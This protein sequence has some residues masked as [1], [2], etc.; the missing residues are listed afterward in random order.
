MKWNHALKLFSW[1]LPQIQTCNYARKK[2]LR[3][4]NRAATRA[5]PW[6]WVKPPFHKSMSHISIFHSVSSH[7]FARIYAD[8]KSGHTRGI[9]LT[10]S[11]RSCARNP[12]NVPNVDENVDHRP[13]TT[14]DRWMVGGKAAALEDGRTFR[15]TSSEGNKKIWDSTHRTA[16]G[17]N[18]PWVLKGSQDDITMIIIVMCLYVVINFHFLFS[19]AN[20]NHHR[21]QKI[22]KIALGDTKLPQSFGVG[23]KVLYFQHMEASSIEKKNVLERKRRVK[24]CISTILRVALCEQCVVVPI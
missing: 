21:D 14:M 6:T 22:R 24:R 16:R 19:V 18:L 8:A 13:T 10:P 11:S 3:L 4:S 5:S 12:V 1:N 7:R 17:G 9:P 2:S 15:G 23:W 20:L